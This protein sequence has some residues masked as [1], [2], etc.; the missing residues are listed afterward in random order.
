M[1]GTGKST[2]ARTVTRRCHEEGRLGASFFFARGG[3]E[4]ETARMFVTTIAVQLARRFGLL[5]T[6][7]CKALAANPDIAGE[8]LSDQWKALVLRPCQTLSASGALKSALVVVVDALDECNNEREIEFVLQLLSE[9]S[10]LEVSQLLL[11]LTSRPEM[12][13]RESINEIPETERQ[14]LILHRI[15]P[16]VVDHDIRV[17]LEQRLGSLI[18]TLPNRAAVSADDILQQ[19]VEKACGLF[20][21]AA[22][23]SRFVK[24]GRASARKRL[25][26]ILRDGTSSASDHPQ[27]SLDNLMPK[28]AAARVARELSSGGTRRPLQLVEEPCLAPS[29][30]LFS[31]LSA[32]SL[33]SL[34]Q[35]PETEIPDVLYDLHSIFDVPDEPHLPIRPP[36]RLG[37]RLFCWTTGDAATIVFWVDEHQAHAHIADQCLWLLGDNLRKDMCGLRHPGVLVNDVPQNRRDTCIPPELRYACLYWVRHVDRSQ[38]TQQLEEP[39]HQFLMKHFLHWLEALSLVGRLA[40]G[41]EMITVLESLYV[42]QHYPADRI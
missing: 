36:T 18:R 5:K 34:L 2:I 23:A 26:T 38:N 32:P 30:V 37:A 41:V 9:G 12:P 15:A 6:L 42:S 3:G 19:L 31:S 8:A 35:F 27:K 13:I 1:A 33:A 11:F 17:F 25:E 22:T 10:S 39:I 20:M 40:D 16:D 21:W 28:R 24:E 14:H 4:L 29:P 7:I